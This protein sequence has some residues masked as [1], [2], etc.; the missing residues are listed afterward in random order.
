MSSPVRE[1]L[2][3]SLVGML[4]V[5]IILAIIVVAGHFLM[6][7][8]KKTDFVLNEDGIQ[9]ESVNKIHEEIIKKAISQWSNNK[10]SVKKINQ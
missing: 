3:T 7:I 10:A 4:T 5:F 2:L 8:L 1:A 6:S 9:K